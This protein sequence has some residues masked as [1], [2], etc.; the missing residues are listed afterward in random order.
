[1]RRKA[2][3][4]TEQV[5]DLL[6]SVLNGDLPVPEVDPDQLPA[7]IAALKDDRDE[8]IGR[9]WTDNTERSDQL[10][11]LSRQRSNEVARLRDQQAR[12][13][14]IRQRCDCAVQELS[15]L[16]AQLS[17]EEEE[18]RRAN[19]EKRAELEARQ[20]AELE[21][22]QNVWRTA[23]KGRF[24]NRSSSL[25]RELRCRS[26]LLLNAHRSQEI[27]ESEAQADGQEA[28]EIGR[29]HRSPLQLSLEV[30]RNVRKLL[31]DVSHNVPL[32]CRRERGAALVQ[33]L[34]KP[35]CELTP[36]KV[37]RESS[38]WKGITLVGWNRLDTST[39]CGAAISTAAGE[40][41]RHRRATLRYGLQI[42]R[43]DRISQFREGV[44]AI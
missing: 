24:L 23:A 41:S 15:D 5:Q 33:D 28:R 13:G 11:H 40:S 26:I 34:L 7:L 6:F 10:L 8:K 35:R 14:R 20:G 43:A 2:R 19:A 27:Q 42:C 22:M 31:F 18:M 37:K 3:L 30:K 16:Q 25:L 17:G 39:E 12:E 38:V 44:T 29:S 21:A 1:V 9:H 4:T 36:D 32:R